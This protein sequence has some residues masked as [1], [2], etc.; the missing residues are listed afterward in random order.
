MICYFCRKVIYSSKAKAKRH[1]RHTLSQCKSTYPCPEGNGWH[2]TRL[3]QGKLLSS[4][5]VET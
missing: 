1:M 2:L 4:T 3:K 5:N